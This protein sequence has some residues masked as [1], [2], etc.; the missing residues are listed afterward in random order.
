MEGLDRHRVTGI[1]GARSKADA[2]S[3]RQLAAQL[4]TEYGKLSGLVRLVNLPGEMKAKVRAGDA[5]TCK[6]GLAAA[7][8]L[9]R[10]K[11]GGE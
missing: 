10:T 3:A 1:R 6:M 5:Q 11:R 2:L 4:D 7:L 9:M 8:D